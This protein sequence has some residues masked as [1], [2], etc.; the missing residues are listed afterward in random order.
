[1]SHIMVKKAIVFVSQLLG[2][3]KLVGIEPRRKRNEPKM[4]KPN[5]G[6]VREEV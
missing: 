5:G 3:G 4:G 1:M 2:N 6:E